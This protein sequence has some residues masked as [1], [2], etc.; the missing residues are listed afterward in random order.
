MLFRSQDRDWVIETIA[1]V[2]A[3]VP[4]ETRP[5][6]PP[7]FRFEVDHTTSAATTKITI[8]LGWDEATLERLVGPGRTERV[9][10]YRDTTMVRV[11]LS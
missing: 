2:L 5:M 8:D 7:P 10:R 3:W 4:G 1:P 11:R 9:G 6:K